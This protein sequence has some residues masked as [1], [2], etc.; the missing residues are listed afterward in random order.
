MSIIVKMCLV[1]IL[2]RVVD[3]YPILVGANREEHYGREATAPQIWPGP[4]GVLAGKDLLAGGT[5]LGVNSDGVLV[6][7]T[8]RP[9][10]APDPARSRGLLCRDLLLCSRASLAREHALR[11]LTEQA[12]AGCNLFIAGKDGAFVIHSAERLV[13]CPV[14]PGIHVLTQANLNDPSD[15][16]IARSL[17]WLQ[18]AKLTHAFGQATFGDEP[19]P[20]LRTRPLEDW[21]EALRALCREH[22]SADWPPICL[23]SGDRGTVSSSIIGLASDPD[24]ALWQHAQGPP[25]R[26]PYEDYSGLLGRLL[27]S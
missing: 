25:C 8:N 10:R 16:R 12:Y 6:A 23:H 19:A 13:A 26:T 1:A 22:G 4:R 11:E 21:L 24:A 14:E 7:I 3:G 9:K 2:Y 17:E 5:W 20:E 18:H 27:K 15:R